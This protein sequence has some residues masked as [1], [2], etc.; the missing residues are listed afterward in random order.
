MA[1]ALEAIE[2]Q[3]RYVPPP[4]D[5]LPV[6]ESLP[7]TRIYKETQ[8]IVDSYTEWAQ[9]DWPAHIKAARLNHHQHMATR[10]GPPEERVPLAFPH[11]FMDEAARMDLLSI[12][13]P[14]EYGGM[15]LTPLQKVIL[16]EALARV[17]TG[18]QLKITVHGSLSGGAL[19]LLGTKAQKQQYLP[20]MASGEI[21]GFFGLTEPGVGSDATNLQCKAEKVEGGWKLNGRK[22]F[23]TSA[24]GTVGEQGRPGV[25]IGFMRTG[26]P[27]K[28]GI[29]A[30]L[31]PMRPNDPRAQVTPMPMHGQHLSHVNDIVFDD[32]IIPEDSILGGPGELNNGWLAG[33]RILSHSRNWI[34]AQGTGTA[35]HAY[36]EA[37]KYAFEREMFGEHQSDLPLNKRELA[38]MKREID[39]ARLLLRKAAWEEQEGTKYAHIYASLAKLYAGL[40][41]KGEPHE[42]QLI[43]GGMGYSAETEIGYIAT[44]G[45]VI[46]IY[47]GGRHVQI[48]LILDHLIADR[49]MLER[50][51][52]VEE[53]RE[54]EKMLQ[55][56]WPRNDHQIQ[57]IEELPT[58]EETILQIERWEI[59]RKPRLAA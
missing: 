8:K 13:L 58:A 38:H 20:G 55:A 35:M 16:S 53:R 29:T 1:Q 41:A 30:F 22:Q 40:V 27:G 11:G 19:A 52:L 26:Q 50:G 9:R 5:A 4:I 47:E 33:Q 7:Y 45:E 31:V 17:D 23:I 39:I 6:I 51:E 56:I 59:G 12:D 48:N 57:P 32:Y 46:D 3:G 49:K 34:A 54:A 25:M 42:A 18:G 15:G 44:D 14:E 21:Y 28:E 2:A 36:D 24:N 10:E 43:H 37:V